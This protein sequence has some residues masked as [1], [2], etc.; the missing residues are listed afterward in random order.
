[1]L[2]IFSSFMVRQHS[3]PYV[4]SLL[5]FRLHTQTH[6]TRKD[7][8]GRVIDLWQRLLSDNIQH[9]QQ[10]YMPSGGLEPAIPA[11]EIPQT[12]ALD[13]ADTW[14]GAFHLVASIDSPC[15]YFTSSPY[16]LWHE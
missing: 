8:S 15:R 5:R 9:S 12:H 16:A 6:N 14:M 11:S 4:S 7:S 13:R 2:S 10:T 1:L 3:G